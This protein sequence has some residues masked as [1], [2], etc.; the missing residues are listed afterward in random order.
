M[1][2]WAI[3]WRCL[4]V[5]LLSTSPGLASPDQP[6]SGERPYYD[7]NKLFSDCTEKDPV[8][9]GLCSG[10]IIGVFDSHAAY[11]ALLPYGAI[12]LFCPPQGAAAGQVRDI[13]VRYLETHPETLQYTAASE[14]IVALM[15]AFPCASGKPQ[16]R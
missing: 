8:S 6:T 4:A 14:I 13:V 15:D 7:G 10:Y 5:A 9:D 2:V 16:Q 3:G 12:N 11:L 1:T